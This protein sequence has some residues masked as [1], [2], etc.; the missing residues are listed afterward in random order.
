MDVC[1]HG[2]CRSRP[3]LTAVVKAENGKG[4]PASKWSGN[5]C[6]DHWEFAVIWQVQNLGRNDR[7]TIKKWRHQ[8]GGG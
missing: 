5:F 6:N 3:D 4:R 8:D 2:D 1:R 7:L